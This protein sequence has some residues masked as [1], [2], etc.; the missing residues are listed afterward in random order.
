MSIGVNFFDDN[1]AAHLAAAEPALVRAL[2]MA[3]QHALA[4]GVLGAMQIQ[5]NRPAQGIAEC[6]HALALDRNLALAHGWIG[7]AKAWFGR[8][9]E[10]EAHVNEAL[11]LSPRDTSSPFGGCSS[12]LA[13]LLLGA[14]AEAAV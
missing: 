1:R 6:E 5:T 4:H 9:D 12:V 13:K 11:R 3:P 2:S 7:I 8:P 10:T 14:D